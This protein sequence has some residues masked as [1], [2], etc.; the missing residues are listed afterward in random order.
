MFQKALDITPNHIPSLYHLGLMQHKNLE[1]KEALNSFT[2]VLEKIG[3]DRLV[4][5][6]RGL[7][8]Q[9]MKNHEYAINDL[10]KAIEIGQ[11]L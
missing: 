5:E 3:D 4:Y 6:S 8:Y 7:V 11:L 9:D 1:L 2:D 10:N